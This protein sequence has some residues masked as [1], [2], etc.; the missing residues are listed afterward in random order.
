M[1]EARQAFFV[2]A[3]RGNEIAFRWLVE[4]CECRAQLMIEHLQGLGLNP[5]RAW[6]IS[7]GRWLTVAHPEHAGQ[8]YKWNSHVAPTLA[9]DGVEHG[10]LVIDPSLSPTGPLTVTAWAGAMRARSIELA[11]IGLSEAEVLD[12]QAARTLEGRTLDA[13]VFLLAVGEPPVRNR[14]GTAMSSTGAWSSAL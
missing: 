5:G 12:L 3:A 4:G 10:V 11:R 6:A 1:E 2:V 13:V 14:G 7:V 8:S 9:V